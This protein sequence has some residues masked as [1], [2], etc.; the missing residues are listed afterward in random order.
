VTR[1]SKR[2]QA[3][4]LAFFFASSARIFAQT[5][6][7]I[8]GTIA[9]TSGT[10]LPVTVALD[11]TATLDLKLRIVVREAVTDSGEVP[12]VDVISTTSGTNYTNTVS[13]PRFPRQAISPSLFS[14]AQG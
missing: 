5:T 3:L 12:L 8:E 6:G 1:K 11:S 2:A 4:F 10:P 9:D 7:Q 14:S 13:M